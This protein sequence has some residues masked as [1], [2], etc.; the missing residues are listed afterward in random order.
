MVPFDD[1]ACVWGEQRTWSCV[2]VCVRVHAYACD[3]VTA[4]KT[5]REKERDQVCDRD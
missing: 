5:K 1:P 2:C 4:I 3:R